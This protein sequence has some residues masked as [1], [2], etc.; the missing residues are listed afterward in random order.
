MKY[1]AQKVHYIV[2]TGIIVKDDTFLIT[3]RASTEKA[4]PNLWTIPG[5]KL[6]LD[7]YVKRQ[8][9]TSTHWYNIF[10]DLVKREIMEKEEKSNCV[11]LLPNMHGLLSNKQKNMILLKVFM[12]NWKCLINT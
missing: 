6:Q 10:E 4:F 5:D 2:V 7:D 1:D 11:P 12:K 9:D 8:K 3:K